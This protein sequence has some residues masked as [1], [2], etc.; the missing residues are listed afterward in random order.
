MFSLIYLWI[1]G[2]VNNREA[3]VLRR[4][5][6]HYEIPG[7]TIIFKLHTGIKSNE[8]SDTLHIASDAYCSM[9]QYIEYSQMNC[10]TNQR[11]THSVM[12]LK[13][14]RLTTDRNAI[15]GKSWSG[16]PITSGWVLQWRHMSITPS[17]ITGNLTL[18]CHG[19]RPSVEMNEYILIVCPSNIFI[20]NN[21]VLSKWNHSKWA[22]RCHTNW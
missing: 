4:H 17:Q 21:F 5:G 19:A 8:Y 7:F 18:L 13:C 1:N 3:G 12:S 15:H 20:L 22:T 2:W 6:T 9:K 11:N 16:G 10:I 14:Y